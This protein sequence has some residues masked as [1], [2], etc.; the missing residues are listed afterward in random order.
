[1]QQRREQRHQGNRNMDDKYIAHR[2]FNIVINSPSIF[3]GF[4]DSGEIIIQQDHICRFAGNV[5]TAFSH[6]DTDVGEF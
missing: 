4:N 1:M 5:S 6:R 2:L 3:D